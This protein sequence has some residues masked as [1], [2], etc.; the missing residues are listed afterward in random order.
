MDL[1]PRK[2]KRNKLTRAS[3][4][5]VT[6]AKYAARQGDGDRRGVTVSS[7]SHTTGHATPKRVVF[8]CAALGHMRSLTCPLAALPNTGA[9][10]HP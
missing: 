9:V 2:R 7:R 8:L 6:Q 3:R 4:W 1:P 5:G 10:A